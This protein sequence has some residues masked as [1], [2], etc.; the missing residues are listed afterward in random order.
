[1]LADNGHPIVRLVRQIAVAE[2]IRLAP[3]DELLRRYAKHDDHQAFEIL[4]HRHGVMV[5]G[6]CCN[7]LGRSQA[8]EDALQATFLVL[9]RKAKAIARPEHLANWLYGVAHRVALRTRQTAARQAARDMLATPS[10]TSRTA[11]EDD[12]PDLEILHQ[13]LQRLPA[14]YRAAMV[15]C[16]F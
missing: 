11:D 6:V 9:I 7:I 13:E 1:M 4:V 10:T 2:E 14:K 3:D 15:L 12:L 5:W 8:A 16:Y